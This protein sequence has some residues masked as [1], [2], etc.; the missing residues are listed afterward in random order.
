MNFNSKRSVVF[1]VR[2]VISLCFLA[3][4]RSLESD[5]LT[6]SVQEWILILNG[7]WFSVRRVISLC[8][9]NF[10]S[11]SWELVLWI[12]L[13][14]N[15]LSSHVQWSRMNFNS[16]QSVVFSGRRVISLWSLTSVRSLESNGLTYSAQEWI[17]ILNGRR[18][19]RKREEWSLISAVVLFSA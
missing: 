9:L 14:C 8:F 19:F 5:G 12:M 4:V 2:R 3:S 18:S 11:L 7:R 17:L 15:N 1:S 16:K 6:Y 10:C 13:A